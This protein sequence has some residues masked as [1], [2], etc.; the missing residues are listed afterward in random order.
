MTNEQI[1]QAI[2]EM[3][4]EAAK[5]AIHQAA[6]DE[7]IK[8][9]FI[10]IDELK[11]LHISVQKL[12]LSVE[13]QTGELARTNERQAAIQTDLNEVK[14]KPAKRWDAI[15]MALIGAVVSAVIGWFAGKG[16]G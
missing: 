9:A 2:L 12:A 15:V 14:A 4:E 7:K 16:G 13:R 3:R 1:T 5:S 8:A 11:E 6:L 10:R